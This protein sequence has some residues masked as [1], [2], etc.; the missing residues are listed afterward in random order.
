MA[1]SRPNQSMSS[2]AKYFSV[3]SNCSS[4]TGMDSGGVS[5]QCQGVGVSAVLITDCGGFK[6]SAGPSHTVHGL[7]TQ[8]LNLHWR[9]RPN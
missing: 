7:S 2:F 4:E 3:F 1:K 9:S 6:G 5:L 8:V